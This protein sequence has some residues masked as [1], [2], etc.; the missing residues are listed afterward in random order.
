MPSIEINGAAHEVKLTWAAH[1]ALKEQLGA[2][3][4]EVI[5]KSHDQRDLNTLATALAAATEGLDV[6]EIYEAS[7][8]ITLMYEAL[9]EAMLVSFYGP[10]KTPE[11]EDG[12]KK[13]ISLST[14]FAMSRGP[15][16]GTE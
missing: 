14:L 5:Q 4:T 15:R 7:P 12:A 11:G 2:E 3:Y 8:P 13:K 10:S 9:I 1:E 16:S 6:K